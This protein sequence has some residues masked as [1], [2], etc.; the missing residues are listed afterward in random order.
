MAKATEHEVIRAVLEMYRSMPFLWK[1][2]DEDY[3]NKAAREEGCKVLLD[4]Y[5]EWDA[6]C[7]MR[8]LKRKIENLRSNYIKERKK[9]LTS[10]KAGGKIYV[11]NL[12]YYNLLTFLNRRPYVDD[13]SSQDPLDNEQND[14]QNSDEEVLTKA[15]S[16]TRKRKLER[17][18]AERRSHPL[19]VARKYLP[20]QRPESWEVTYGKS[21]GHQMKDLNGD[22]LA[23]CQ[24]IISD[25]VFFAKLNKLNEN[26]HIVNPDTLDE[27]P[28]YL[29]TSE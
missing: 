27:E 25:A 21:I 3:L 24:K 13:D 2:D 26:S 20:T 28:E 29:E 1:R 16:N 10:Q 12:W 8:G 14:D 9:V 15:E 22:Q 11:P 6:D 17:P 23:I 4:I 18:I 5:H 19:D 7:T